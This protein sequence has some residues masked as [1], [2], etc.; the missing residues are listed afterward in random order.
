MFSR[1]DDS[2]ISLI[3]RIAALSNLTEAWRR[4]RGNIAVAR[5]PHSFGVDEVSVFAFEQQW[6]ANLA[7]LSRALVEGSY[8]SLPVRRVEIGKPGGGKRTI[9]VLA[10]RDRIAQRAAQQV[11][12][13]LFEAQ[14]LDCSYGFRP[15]RSVEDAV[16]RVLCYH[17]A[18]CAWAFHADVAAC[19]DRLDH[20]LLMKFIGQTVRERTVLDLIQGWL[21]AQ[22]L[23]VDSAVQAT[24]R[25]ERW[26]ERVGKVL[27]PWVDRETPGYGYDPLD[28]GADYGEPGWNEEARRREV[29]KHLGSEALWLGLTLARPLAGQVRPALRALKRRK[30]V[31]LGAAGV[32]GAAAAA[33]AWW[34]LRHDT[35]AGCGTLQGGALSPLLANVYLHP[36]DLA[37][38]DREHNLV[39][40]ADDFLVCCPTE[41][42]AQRA[43][44]DAAKVLADLRL[45]LSPEKTQLVSFE[46]GF[47]F[48]GHHFQG[49]GL[50]PVGGERVRRG[51]APPLRLG[52]GQALRLGSG[53]ALRL[54]SGQ[55]L[56]RGREVVDRLL[57]PLRRSPKPSQGW[58]STKEVN[59][60]QES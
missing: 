1:R 57:E 28:F 33:S 22:M 9:G 38:T 56:R 44:Q 11:L 19:F 8:Q 7:E 34:A 16:Q 49:H 27:E 54:G 3:E 47:H 53:Q 5:R 24:G 20:G 13:P 25:W 58:L 45:A 18:G 29:W 41:E 30:G 26:A 10:V 2:S 55:A 40:Y 43:G 15:R 48:L 17:Q 59:D 35:P 32:V 42:E 23:E 39:R 21:E 14:F 50:A 4:V 12:E 52:S 46:Q 60:E 31:V 6:E 37:M 36:F 51:A